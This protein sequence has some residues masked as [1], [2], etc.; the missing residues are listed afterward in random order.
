MTRADEQA[1]AEART[2]R[3]EA[4]TLVRQDIDRLR[5]GLSERPIGQRIKDHAVDE[6]MDVIDGAVSVA[7]DN[8]A[9]IGA[10]LAALAGWALRG[11]L[12]KL[13]QDRLPDDAREWLQFKGD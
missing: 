2:L 3:T 1:L 13:V 11:P 4:W 6:A 12:W 7:S 10:T 5:E 9:V 8:K